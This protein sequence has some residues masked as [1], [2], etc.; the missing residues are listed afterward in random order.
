MA[1]EAELTPSRLD[2]RVGKVVKV[3]RHPDAENLYLSKID[4]GEAAPRTIVSGLVDFVPQAEMEGRLVVMLANLEPAK[5]RGVESCGMVL[6]SSREELKEVETLGVLEGAVVGD[7]VGV[8][9]QE[10][11]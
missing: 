2:I 6:C 8:E 3:A 7:R 11:G 10:E 5:M 1:G 9:G 4:L